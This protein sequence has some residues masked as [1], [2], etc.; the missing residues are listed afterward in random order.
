M[1]RYIGEPPVKSCA[2]CGAVMAL[3]ERECPACGYSPPHPG[4]EIAEDLTGAL[5]LIDEQMIMEAM[6]D[7]RPY[8]EVLGLVRTREHLEIIA[9]AKG[10]RPGWIWHTARELGLK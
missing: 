4:G 9:M 6:A 1:D 8:R 5:H 7:E 2:A 3:S 10:Y